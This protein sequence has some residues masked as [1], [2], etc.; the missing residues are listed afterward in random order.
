MAVTDGEITFRQAKINNDTSA[1][2]GWASGTL[3]AQVFPNVEV[4]ER[5]AGLT[6]WRKIFVHIANA[7][8]T[9]FRYPGAVL[10]RLPE[11]DDTVVWTPATHTNTQGDLT[12]SETL[13][14]AGYLDAAVLAGGTS[15]SVATEDGAIT[16]FRPGDKILIARFETVGGALTMTAVETAVIDAG[17]VSG[18]G[19]V[20]TLTLTAGLSA[21]YSS[22]KVTDGNGR[23]TAY[24]IVGSRYEW[25]DSALAETEN[26]AVS[27]AGGSYNI[28]SYPIILDGRGTVYQNWTLA[29]TSGTAFTVTG[30]TL[31]LIGSGNIS[32]NTAPTNPDF[33]A[34]Y[35]TLNAAG[36]S[37]TFAT[38]NSVTF[39]TVPAMLPIFVKQVVPVGAAPFSD[40]RWRLRVDGQSA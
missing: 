10:L 2:G 17:G 21:G 28:G 3:V 15:L 7:A 26:F 4:A 39:R 6:R 27:S 23:L 22:T 20:K 13:Y 24:A 29:F 25:P 14:G 35:F 9:E 12:G 32:G 34:P 37:G 18:V 36:F 5:A 38:G 11:G 33:S 31:G 40:D 30:D 16:I 1:N 19:G 8:N